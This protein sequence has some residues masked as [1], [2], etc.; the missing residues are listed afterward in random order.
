MLD[1]RNAAFNVTH[2]P[3]IFQ[4]DNAKPNPAHITKTWL[5][6]VVVQMMDWLVNSPNLSPKE[7]VENF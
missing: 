5:R 1:V 6:K 2:F 7:C 3:H 4:Q